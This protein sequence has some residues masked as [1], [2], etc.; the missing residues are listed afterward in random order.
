[1]ASLLDMPKAMQ[2][3][4]HICT[5]MQGSCHPTLRGASGDHPLMADWDKDANE[6]AG[7]H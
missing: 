4:W 6:K 2:N 3:A 5:G 7:L 1:M